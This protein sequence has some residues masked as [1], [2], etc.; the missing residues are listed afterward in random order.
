MTD[1]S[2]EASGSFS[3]IRA[4]TPDDWVPG[5][6]CRLGARLLRSLAAVFHLRR[7]R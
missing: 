1:A 7:P 2:A 4:A 3:S 6:L 5:R